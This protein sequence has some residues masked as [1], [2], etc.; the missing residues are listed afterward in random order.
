[1]RVC[2][3]EK[4]PIESEDNW[5]NEM[6]W[7]TAVHGQTFGV[8]NRGHYPGTRRWMDGADCRSRMVDLNHVE[9]R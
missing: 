6:W 2:G 1:M 5:E 3:R 8:R 7:R 4:D 9:L